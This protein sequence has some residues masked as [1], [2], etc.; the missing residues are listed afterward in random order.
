M[1]CTRNHK[2]EEKF[3]QNRIT[4]NKIDQNRKPHTKLSKPDTMA[5]R[6]AYRANY[7]NT[8]FIKVFVNDRDF[9]EAFVNMFS[10][11]LKSQALFLPLSRAQ[12]NLP[13]TG[14]FSERQLVM[15]PSQ[16]I[17]IR[18]KV[19]SRTTILQAKKAMTL[20]ISIENL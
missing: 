19:L 12:T 1:G 9:S 13:K 16:H 7:T 17:R 2:T 10:H 18:I 3:I 20:E 11:L 15:E 6:E 8:N 4:A 14:S 5:T